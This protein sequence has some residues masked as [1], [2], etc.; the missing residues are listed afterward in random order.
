[1][2]QNNKMASYYNAYGGLDNQVSKAFGTPLGLN[3]VSLRHFEQIHGWLHYMIGGAP[4]DNLHVGNMW[5]VEYSAFEPLFMLHHWCV[6][7][8]ISARRMLADMSNSNVDRLFA[9]WEAVHPDLYLE[10]FKV[11][12]GRNMWLPLNSNADEN[13]PLQPFWRTPGTFWTSKDVR[14]TTALNYAYIETQ[15]WNFLNMDAYRSAVNVTIAQLYS[16]TTR[17]ALTNGAAQAEDGLGRLLNDDNTFTDWNI[18]IEGLRMRLPSTFV[19]RFSFT[20]D[21]ADVGSWNVLMPKSAQSAQADKA[22]RMSTFEPKLTG[23]VELTASLL[24]LITAGKLQSLQ[25]SDV[26][27]YLTENLVWK[28]YAVGCLLFYFEHVNS[29]LQDNGNVLSDTELDALTAEVVSSNVRIPENPNQPVE[30]SL[31][32]TPYPEVTKGRPGGVKD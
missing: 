25:P 13:T 6:Q 31:D 18:R 9:I 16:S 7:L 19:M 22:K 15:P 26:V 21:A 23:S 20:G 3:D 11:T 4:P 8:I 12:D 5:P 29:L 17:V 14:D 2:S 32:M 1:M 10:P 24:D 30:Y 28:V 27:P